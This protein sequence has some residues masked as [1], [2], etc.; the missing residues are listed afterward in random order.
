M[1]EMHRQSV[2]V[3][4]KEN[5]ATPQALGSILFGLNAVFEVTVEKHF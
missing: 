3:L 5:L 4:G 2:H 1:I